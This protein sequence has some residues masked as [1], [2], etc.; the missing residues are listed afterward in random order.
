M[1]TIKQSS[2]TK[3]LPTI[4]AVASLIAISSAYSAVIVTAGT[5]EGIGG[6]VVTKPGAAVVADYSNS[7]TDGMIHLLLDMG[8][9]R[10]VALL[11]IVNRD[12]ATDM[13]IKSLSIWIAPDES[14]PGFDPFSLST[15][16]VN[17]Y[18][19]Q[20]LMPAVNGAN[21]IRPVDVTD[22]SRRYVLINLSSNFQTGGAPF[23][24]QAGSNYG[25]AQL[26]DITIA[27]AVPE[28]HA[29]GLLIIGGAFSLTRMLRR[30]RLRS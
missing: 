1:R 27:T 17:V 20:N 28:P 24:Y 5:L 4:A 2:R 18:A 9:I 22:F 13:S 6:S 10:D 25:R 14:A 21:A 15:Y 30:N 7:Q 26:G 12:V 29:V 11:N 3:I 16:T 8:D 23:W 19:N